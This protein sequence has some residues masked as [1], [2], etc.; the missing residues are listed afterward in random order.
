MIVTVH[1]FATGFGKCQFSCFGAQDMCLM[2]QVTENGI[3]TE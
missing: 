1:L 2:V 3:Q